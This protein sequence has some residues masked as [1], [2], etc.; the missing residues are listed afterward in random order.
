[1]DTQALSHA[2]LSHL[3]P[4]LHQQ[5]GSLPPLGFIESLEELDSM[6]SLSKEGHV[7]VDL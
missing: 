6:I 7:I 2:E 1:M 3:L 5:S 4:Y